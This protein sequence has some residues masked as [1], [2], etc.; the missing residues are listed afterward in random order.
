M[1]SY[2][3]FGTAHFESVFF[4]PRW[5]K[6]C[7]LGYRK[8]GY[9]FQRDSHTHLVANKDNQKQESA[10]CVLK[11]ETN[12]MLTFRHNKIGHNLNF[13][14]QCHPKT[15]RVLYI[16]YK[17]I[18]LTMELGQDSKQKN[19]KLITEYHIITYHLAAEN[20]V[21]QKYDES[22]FEQRLSCHT[23]C[24]WMYP[25]RKKLQFLTLSS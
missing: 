17:A 16:I 3:V 25:T 11:E 22:C 19:T 14:L 15:E 20:Y 1:T 18:S 10:M 24:C 9:V 5:C 2:S 8:W 6:S 4:L 12:Y 21:N 23:C 7:V 13:S